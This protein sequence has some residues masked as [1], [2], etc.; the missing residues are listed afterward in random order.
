M[1]LKSHTIN[2][3]AGTEQ[4]SLTSRVALFQYLMG[5]YLRYTDE[6]SSPLPHLHGGDNFQRDQ[7]LDMPHHIQR[8][9]SGNESLAAASAFPAVTH[10][11]DAAVKSH[12]GC[13]SSWS[14]VWPFGNFRAVTG[15][16]SHS[17]SPKPIR[18][19]S[20]SPTTRTQYHQ[21]PSC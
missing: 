5:G 19:H 7:A 17:S 9:R 16:R 15:P 21:H 2:D 18:C 3:S 14:L 10:R 12:T 20:W 1:L 13:L 4:C 11:L 6:G 8:G